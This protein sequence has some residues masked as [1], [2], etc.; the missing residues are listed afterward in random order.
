MADAGTHPLDSFS[1]CE[2]SDALIKLGVLHGGHI[3]DI[4]CQLSGD[5]VSV[6]GP[7]YTVQMVK[8]SDTKSPK[9]EAHFVD[10]IV[11]GSVVVIQAPRELHN[12]VWGGL[13]TAGA[14][15]RGAKGVIISGRC[16]DIRESAAAGFPVFARGRSTLG[17]G[18]FTRASAVQ[19]PLAI[20]TNS[21]AGP[22]LF[23]LPQGL[24]E[25]VV[26]PGDYVVADCDGVVCVPADLFEELAA[27]AAKGR[28]VDE[29]CLEDI[30]KGL[31]VQ[32][33]F[34]KYRGK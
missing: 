10:T 29:K 14:Q 23:P 25:V 30:R 8:A 27:V 1:S 32:D 16:R 24:R 7:A 15:S 13:M 12:A 17:Q 26:R 18:G 6:R 19:V 31:G 11:E 9:L 22:P 34:K 2:L 5:D 28:E 33:S 21:A 20:S 3:P 4:V